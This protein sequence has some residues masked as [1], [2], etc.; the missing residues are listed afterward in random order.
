MFRRKKKEINIE[1][2][3]LIKDLDDLTLIPESLRKL[4]SRFALGTELTK[5]GH[6]VSGNGPVKNYR[7]RIVIK[8][9]LNI[10]YLGI[11]EPIRYTD[12]KNKRDLNLT[13]R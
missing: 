5:L 3:L 12:A 9:V 13:Y 8:H 1:A 2:K 10:A 7:D 11:N 4:F 6:L